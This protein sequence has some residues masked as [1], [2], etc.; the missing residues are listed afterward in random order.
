MCDD[1]W[2]VHDRSRTTAEITMEYYRTI[3]QDAG[4]DS[5]IIGCNAIGHLVAGYAHLNRIGCDTSGSERRFGV[6]SLALRIFYDIDAGCVGIMGKIDWKYNGQWLKLLSMSGTPLFVSCKPGV[7]S[8]EKRDDLRRAFA[9]ASRR[10]HR[11][12][13]NHLSA[14]LACERPESDI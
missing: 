3:R 14:A 7:T 11:L 6:N 4:E 1:G 10:A 9:R 2:H 8:P 5:V 12:D 13:G